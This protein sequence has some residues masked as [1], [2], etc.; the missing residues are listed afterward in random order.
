M[1]TMDVAVKDNAYDYKNLSNYND[2]IILMAYDQYSVAGDP[3]PISAQKWIEEALDWTAKQINPEKIIL[4]VGG[5]G[6][7]DWFKTVGGKDTIK[8]VTYTEA[9]NKAR[10]LNAVIDYNNDS[11]NLTYSYIEEQEGDDGEM[12]K[13][14]HEVW[15]TDAATTFNILRFSDEYD[16]AGTALWRLGSE[17]TRMWNYYNTDLSN[18]GLKT[19]PFNFNLLSTIPI[20]QD[21]VGFDGEG[22]ILDILYAPQVGKIKFEIDTTDQ[23]IAEQ[24]YLQ[25]PS[26]YVIRKFAED[27]TV[28]KGHKLILTFD[29]GPSD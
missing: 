29:D 5:Y 7:Y 16:M 24:E 21:N 9:N 15:F 18:D 8:A 10:V 1:V 22:E 19:H 4:G 11:Y 20:I 25:L 23:L 12:K 2:Y 27:T 6:G 14:K 26:G 17:D 3:G 28:G 13:I